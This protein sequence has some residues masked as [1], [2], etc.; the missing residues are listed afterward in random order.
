MS[1]TV[2]EKQ[3]AGGVTILEV[4]GFIDTSTSAGLE[5]AI[6][7]AHEEKKIRIVLDLSGSEFISSAGW[8]AM[9]AYLKKLRSTGGDLKIAAMAEKVEKVFKLMEFDSLIDAF[10]TVE[11]A[12]KN[13]K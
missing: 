8:G 13:Y 2:T 6:K 7:K 1:L 9:V 11:E 3:S 5:D 12:V 10:K 4:K